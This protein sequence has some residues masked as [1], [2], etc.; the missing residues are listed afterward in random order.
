MA[1]TSAS[2]TRST[3]VYLP[4]EEAPAMRIPARVAP[5][6][7]TEGLQVGPRHGAMSIRLGSWVAH[8]RCDLKYFP[9]N[10]RQ[11]P[12]TSRAGRSSP[13]PAPACSRAPNGLLAISDIDHGS[14]SGGRFFKNL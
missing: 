1:F 2:F 11:E 6:A 4:D 9:R 7:P 8:G 12:G 5:E 13:R 3:V 10:S 14:G